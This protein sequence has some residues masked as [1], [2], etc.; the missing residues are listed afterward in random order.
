VTRLQ[1]AINDVL[2]PVG[3]TERSHNMQNRSNT[4]LFEGHQGSFPWD[5]AAETA[6]YNG[7]TR[8]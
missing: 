7:K 6:S 2:N 1:T 8:P 4:P 5:K 3:A